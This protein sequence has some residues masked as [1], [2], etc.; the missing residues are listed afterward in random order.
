M[1]ILCGSFTGEFVPRVPRCPAMAIWYQRNCCDISENLQDSCSFFC[2]ILK[3]IAAGLTIIKGV[4]YEVF[5]SGLITYLERLL[6]GFQ[7]RKTNL[8]QRLAIVAQVRKPSW[9]EKST[10]HRDYICQRNPK[11]DSRFWKCILQDSEAALIA[12]LKSKTEIV[13]L[14]FPLFDA[15]IIYQERAIGGYN[16]LQSV[17][18]WQ[19]QNPRNA[20]GIL[21]GKS[22]AFCR[23]PSCGDPH[24]F[25]D[26]AT[27]LGM[28]CDCDPPLNSS[29]GAIFLMHSPTH[30]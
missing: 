19:S 6:V 8:C 21:Q 13:A 2:E 15:Y 17:K 1:W 23:K 30:P 20:K 26:L 11:L 16:R 4:S 24:L 27:S 22:R 10:G 25:L 14:M 29:Q 9:C 3:G 28:P 5:L 7:D 18:G 12:A